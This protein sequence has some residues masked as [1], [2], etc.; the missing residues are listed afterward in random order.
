[1][2]RLMTVTAQE[3]KGQRM[4]DTTGMGQ[5]EYWETVADRRLDLLRECNKW[6][7]EFIPVYYYYP[8]PEVKELMNKLEKRH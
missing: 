5:S 4:I 2:T 1:M 8:E 7:I 3:M 6:L